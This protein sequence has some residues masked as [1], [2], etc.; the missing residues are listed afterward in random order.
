MAIT[1]CNCAKFANLYGE[2]GC[3]P[4]LPLRDLWIPT[5]HA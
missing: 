5:K 4:Q 2:T 3:L 1:L